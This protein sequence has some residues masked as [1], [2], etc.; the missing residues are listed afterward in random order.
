MVFWFSRC[1]VGLRV[2]NT[3]DGWVE[4]EAQQ[5]RCAARAEQPAS[6]PSRSWNTWW[7]LSPAFVAS[8]E[9]RYFLE[10]KDNSGSLGHLDIRSSWKGRDG[11]SGHKE[12]DTIAWLLQEW[13]SFK[14]VSLACDGLCVT[15][16]A[17]WWL[18][19]PAWEI[20]SHCLC[21]PWIWAVCGRVG[22]LGLARNSLRA[23]LS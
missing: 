1:T 15:C 18:I 16:L 14:N 6:C 5:P 4:C 17:G 10:I 3:T 23:G 13:I 9:G 21:L 8:S 20:P 11:R 19:A 2:S 7:I 22:L 12:R